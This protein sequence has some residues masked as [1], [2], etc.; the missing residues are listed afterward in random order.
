MNGSEWAQ[1]CVERSLQLRVQISSGARIPELDGARGVAVLA[2][3]IAHYFGEVDHALIGFSFGWMGVSLFFVLSG[4]LIGS[5]ILERKDSLNFLSV[6]Y[7][8]RALRIMPVYFVTLAATLGFIWLCGSAPWIDEPLSAPFYFTFTQNFVMAWRGET[9]SLWLL[10]TW[11]VAVEEQFY[12]VVPLLMMLVPARALLPAIISGIALC[13]LTRVVLYA[14][15][16]DIASRLL[17]FSN[18]HILLVGVL[19]AYIQQHIKVPEII[20]RLIPLASIAAFD[21]LIFTEQN[22]VFL[23]LM[24]PLFASYI[25][26]A[27]QGWT[28]LRFLRSKVLRSLGAISYCLYLVHQPVNGVLHGF[29]LGG[30]PDIATTPQILVTCTAMI[31]SISIAALSW[32]ALEQ[33]L[34]RLARRKSYS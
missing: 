34:L 1:P 24:A 19:S 3:V 17:L 12:L 22:H 30:R 8:R 6:F 16:A 29:V 25:L 7:T 9:G 11:T 20:L 15:G 10:P 26:L 33:P 23:A 2:V 27:A 28:K 31:V 18:G 4:F 14:T 32:F 21:V 13:F 5:I